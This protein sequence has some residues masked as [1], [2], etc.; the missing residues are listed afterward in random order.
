MTFAPSADPTDDPAT[1]HLYLADGGNASSF[2]GVMEVTLAAAL[3]TAAP[4][5]TATLV[6]RIDT[7]TFV[8]SSP[9]PSGIVY[10]PALDQLMIC[11][12]EVDE[13]TGAGYHGVNLWRITRTGAVQDTGTTVGF[14]NEPTGL[15][16]DPGH[17]HP[18]HLLRRPASHL[19]P[20]ARTRRTLGQR[21][22]HPELDRHHRVRL[23]YRGSGIRPEHRAPV[24]HR[25]RV[26]GGVRRRPG[27]RRLR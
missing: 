11:D 3:V 21:R 22:R 25:R 15:G 12:S 8:P 19:L 5:V 27:Q 17:Q 13:T 24:L 16:F 2:G 18:V 4:V 26:D 6:Q 23:R 7:P 14:S 20:P 10:L 9:D 1:L